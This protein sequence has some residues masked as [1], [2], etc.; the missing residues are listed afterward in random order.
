MDMTTM[1]IKTEQI[2]VSGLTT[3]GNISILSMILWVL[4]HDTNPVRTVLN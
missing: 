4:S 2:Q 3:F 1:T